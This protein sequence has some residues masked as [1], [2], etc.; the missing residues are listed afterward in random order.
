MRSLIR[1]FSL[2]EKI[3]SLGNKNKKIGFCFVLR[4]LIRIFA[5]MNTTKPVLTKEEEKAF[6]EKAGHYLVCFNDQCPLHEECLRWLVGLY[7][8]TTLPA[9]TGVNPRNP[10]NG[11]EQCALFRKKERVMMKRG[12]TH[13]YQEMPR[14]KEHR[15]RLLLQL[16]WG[17]KRYF[18]MRKGE[19]L[20][21]P[22]QQEDV[23]YAC[24]HHGW[25]GPIVYDG[26]VEDWNW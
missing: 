7:V 8:D 4:S 2:C 13:L 17:R 20:V 16:I 19:R 9:Y 10:Q 25:T 21:N 14:Y 11:G 23:I 18:E 24:R 1:N 3:L 22:Q 6:R 12:M 15:I 5:E 26:E